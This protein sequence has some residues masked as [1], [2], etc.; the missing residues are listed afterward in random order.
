MEVCLHN[1]ESKIIYRVKAFALYSIV[2]AHSM[3]T[4]ID[5]EIAVNYLSRISTV[6]MFI[7]LFVCGYY[8]TY[9]GKKHKVSWAQFWKK[10][11]TLFVPWFTNASVYYLLLIRA[12]G[13][14]L[15]LHTYVNFVLRNGLYFYFMT[16]LCLCYVIGWNFY[17]GKPLI[18]KVFC[19]Y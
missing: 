15:S 1:I 11:I 3:Y 2:L 14:E 8:Y 5:N 9:D 7:F 6:G 16:I 18:V 4:N 13:F 12:K 17:Q 10:A 19:M